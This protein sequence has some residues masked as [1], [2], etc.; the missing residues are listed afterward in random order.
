VA[1]SLGGPWAGRFQGAV[2]AR[3]GTEGV[4]GRRERERVGWRTG[5][6]PSG[7]KR[8]SGQEAVGSGLLVGGRLIE[9]RALDRAGSGLEGASARGRRRGRRRSRRKSDAL[10]N[11]PRDRG[12]LDRGEKP[13][14]RAAARTAQGVDLEDALEE[15][16]PSRSSRATGGSQSAVRDRSR[17]LRGGFRIPSDGLASGRSGGHDLAALAGTGRQD[18][19]VPHLVGRGAG[20]LS[21]TR[22]SSR[23]LRSRRTC[24]V[25]S[26]QRVL[27]R[28]VSRPSGFSSRRSFASGGLAA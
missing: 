17:V 16:G 2:R 12:V 14:R 27:R 23:S 22:R 26:R 8:G 10:E 7:C 13:K 20:G 18:P 5:V 15:R 19:V 24:V 11:P 3:A 1:S 9:V 4:P 25:P 6:R 21:G 28:R